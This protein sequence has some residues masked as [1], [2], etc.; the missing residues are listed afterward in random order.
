[1]HVLDLHGYEASLLTVLVGHSTEW[2]LEWVYLVQDHCESGLVLNQ[3]LPVK[4]AHVWF[5]HA[6]LSLLLLQVLAA[7]ISLCIKS[8]KLCF[9]ILIDHWYWPLNFLKLGSYSMFLNLKGIRTHY[10]SGF[11]TL[12]HS[13][14]GGNYETFLCLRGQ[15]IFQALKFFPLWLLGFC[16][17]QYGVIETTNC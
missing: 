14:E 1:M 17:C 9:F 4:A 16:P 3:L 15:S 5:N 11:R 8:I 10:E 7:H 13:F 2:W 6:K 12:V